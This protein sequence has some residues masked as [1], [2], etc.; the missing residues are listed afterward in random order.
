VE[1]ERS[2]GSEKELENSTPEED[3][4]E[5]WFKVAC[6]LASRGKLEEAELAI[7]NA[8]K[9]QN[10]FPIAWAILSAILL[11][12][13]KET[14]AEQAG[15]RAISQCKG[16]KMTW[17]KM[18]SIIFSRGIIRGASWKDP[19]KVVFATDTNSEWGKLLST[20][21]E[22]SQQDISEIPK[23]EEAMDKKDQPY[24]Y[25]FAA[26][27]YDSRADSER[28]TKKE[29][30]KELETYI[31]YAKRSETKTRTREPRKIRE[32]DTQ[33]KSEVVQDSS[34]SSDAASL[35]T[36][37]ESYLKRGKLAKAEEAFVKGLAMDPSKGH[38]WLSLG[39][40]R[41]GRHKYD[42]AI[43]ALKQATDKMPTDS[44]AWF[45]LG[46][47][48]QK[49]NKWK[50][51][52]QPL[53]NALD[54]KQ[55]NPDF[56]MALGLSRYHLGQIEVSAKNFL[57]VLR[58]SPNHKDALFHLAKC[59]EQQGNRKHALSLYLKLIN[60]GGLDHKMLQRLAGAFERLNRPQEASQARSKAAF[61]RS[62]GKR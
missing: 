10:E 37:A 60:L 19:R 55:N 43:P 20:L 41:M 28:L 46:Y 18:R 2:T 16:L 13:G 40:L 3:I 21:G 27:K 57:R 15:K 32:P 58:I 54:I 31:D 9:D 59:M 38:A 52:V 29:E 51:A 44:A 17:P 11:S 14:D 36:A 61:L 5:E 24:M 39:S 56:W 49:M 42:E 33:E 8:L 30:T 25:D 62:T 22:T 6:D 53:K 26:K 4:P 7:R 48:Y 34:E 12:Q 50:K 1:Q 47:C 35:F 45:Q 23:A